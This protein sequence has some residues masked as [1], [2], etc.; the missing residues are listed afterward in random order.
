MSICNFKS[1]G[2]EVKFDYSNLKGMSYVIGENLDLP[3]LRNGVGKSVIFVDA[4]LMVLFGQVANNVKNKGLFHRMAKTNIG[5]IKLQMFVDGQEWNVH[6]ILSRSKSGNVSLSRDLYKGE[7]H[8]DNDVT[9]SSM[10]GTMKFLAEEVIQSDADT[11]KNAVVLSTSNIQN[12]FTLPR[13]AKEAYLDSVFTLAAFGEVYADVKKGLNKLKRELSAQR[14]VHDGL[15]DSHGEI[16]EKSEAFIKE[17]EAELKELTSEINDKR[18]LIERLEKEV[19]DIAKLERKKKLEEDKLKKFEADLADKISKREKIKDDIGDHR[20][21]VDTFAEEQQIILDGSIDDIKTK[22]EEANAQI[23]KA[24]KGIEKIGKQRKKCADEYADLETKLDY[25]K[26]HVDEVSNRRTWVCNELTQMIA[27]K[28]KFEATYEMLC[29]ECQK[30][31]VDHFEFDQE[32]F[33]TLDAENGELE[34]K[35]EKLCDSMDPF[36]EGQ[37]DVDKKLAEIDDNETTVNTAIT[38]LHDQVVAFD[39]KILEERGSFRDAVTAKESEVIQANTAKYHEAVKSNLVQSQKISDKIDACKDEIR[40]IGT[41]LTQAG[42]A[43][44][45]IK[46]ESKLL[47]DFTRRCKKKEG[48]ENPFASLVA[49]GEKKIKTAKKTIK[50][51]LK[52]QRKYEL[53]ANIYDEDGVKRHIVSNIVASLNILIKKYLAEMGTDYTVIFDDK[54]QYNF[55]TATGE[56]E[57]FLFSSGERRRLDMAVMLALRDILFTNGLV[58]NILIVDEVL[59]SGIDGYALFAILNILKNKTKESNLGCIVISHR[60]E[61]LQDLTDTFDRVITV[62]KENSQSTLFRAED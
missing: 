21:E 57:Y 11:F 32:K 48:E 19:A 29:D 47:E 23:K 62:K 42:Y 15:K 24:D 3:E 37:K 31:T 41:E 54:F 50:A 46:D 27:I 13:A 52:D 4:L 59:D 22:I 38:A 43:L 16:L 28:K 17:H 30:K 1:I 5:W 8:E 44:D 33:D 12:F 49:D 9:K 53:L 60:N 51:I 58:T 34:L 56:S 26:T 55:Y 2:E 45:R 20:D 10:A 18:M 7:V 35:R 36:L 6:C 61:I 14:E 40:D 39:V 25:L